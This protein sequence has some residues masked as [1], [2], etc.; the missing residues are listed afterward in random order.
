MMVTAMGVVLD[1]IDPSAED[2]QK[3]IT[4]FNVYDGSS[5]TQELSLIKED[6]AWILN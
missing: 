3:Y 5:G 1:S 4:T 6:G 2:G